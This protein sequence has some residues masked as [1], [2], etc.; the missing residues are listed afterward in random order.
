MCM[1][2]LHAIASPNSSTWHPFALQL[3]SS[4]CRVLAERTTIGV[5]YVEASRGTIVKMVCVWV[6]VSRWCGD[7]HSDKRSQWRATHDMRGLEI[8]HVRVLLAFIR[9]AS[10]IAPCVRKAVI[11]AG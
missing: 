4:T 7:T 1:V 5:E 3:A 2:L 10:F 11:L 6:V 8:S 9:V